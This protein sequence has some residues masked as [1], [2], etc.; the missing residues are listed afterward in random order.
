MREG[1]PRGGSSGF[2][3]VAMTGVR[4]LLRAA[5]AIADP[6]WGS[7]ECW[8]ARG[9]LLVAVKLNLGMVSIN[10]LLNQWVVLHW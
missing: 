1:R 2:G 6:Y 10:V 3:D 7:D 8:A 4:R 9:L 5:W